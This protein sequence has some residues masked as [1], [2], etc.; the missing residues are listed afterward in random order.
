[1]VL[2]HP[3]AEFAPVFF[4]RLYQIARQEE[5]R[6]NKAEDMAITSVRRGTDVGMEERNLLLAIGNALNIPRP[7]ELLDSFEASEADMVE[8]FLEKRGPHY[9][10]AMQFLR[11]YDLTR[12]HMEASLLPERDVLERLVHYY[13]A[14]FGILRTGRISTADHINQIAFVEA[15]RPLPK[16]ATQV[17]VLDDVIDFL[18]TS[19]KQN[20]HAIGIQEPVS[21]PEPTNAHPEWK[22]M[23]L[24]YAAKFFYTSAKGG[25]TRTGIGAISL[26]YFLYVTTGV[27]PEFAGFVIKTAVEAA[28]GRVAQASL[29]NTRKPACRK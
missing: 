10:H 19:Y 1:M 25:S 28:G 12:R 15:G 18:L 11:I 9:N 4:R 17:R 5:E 24:G 26:P 13:G 8:S 7:N 27:D 23:V 29:N 16:E 20:N 21:L 3:S 6:D 14:F 2:T 22:R